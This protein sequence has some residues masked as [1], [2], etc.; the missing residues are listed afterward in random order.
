MC[1]RSV[2][3]EVKGNGVDGIISSPEDSGII[4]RAKLEPKEQTGSFEASCGVRLFGAERRWQHVWGFSPR[5][6]LHFYRPS[7]ICL[8]HISSLPSR[9]WHYPRYCWRASRSQP[10]NSALT[11]H[12]LPYLFP[13]A[14][15]RST[16]NEAD[17]LII[18]GYRYSTY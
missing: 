16:A 8:L 2:S 12:L 6:P 14:R 5:A 4:S 10:R 9:A 3:E 1:A 17:E 15:I 18:G 7:T 11:H 13:A